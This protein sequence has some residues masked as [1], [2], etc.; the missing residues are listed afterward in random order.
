MQLTDSTPETPAADETTPV[1]T[2]V[3]ATPDATLAAA[4]PGGALPPF[5]VLAIVSIITA[6]LI[7]IVGIVTG[8]IALSQIKK[9]GER[10]RGVALAGTI[11]GY[12]VTVFW[13]IGIA[14][15]IIVSVFT[16]TAVSEAANG[17]TEKLGNLSEAVGGPDSDCLA[18]ADTM[19]KISPDLSE[20]MTVMFDDPATA[21]TTLHGIAL[22]LQDSADS[23]EDSDVQTSAWAIAQATEDLAV[24][25]ETGADPTVAADA[26]ES[27]VTDFTTTCGA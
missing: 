7:S 8:H 5:N 27:A 15:L 25:I 12:V 4:Q 19:G 3:I 26:F 23:L 9:R 11:I 14:V 10:G 1:A 17:D 22:T 13:A 24:A 6:F 16:A 18:Y 20:A 21:G 2:E